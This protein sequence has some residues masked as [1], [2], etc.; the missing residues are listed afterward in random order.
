M[1]SHC[2]RRELQG[3]NTP[4][5]LRNRAG[6]QCSGLTGPPN[7]YL[8][9]LRTSTGASSSAFS[10][11]NSNLLEVPG[12]PDLE[13]RHPNGIRLAPDHKPK[14]DTTGGA[15]K[16]FPA[17]PRNTKARHHLIMFLGASICLCMVC[18]AT[19]RA[20]RGPGPPELLQVEMN[21]RGTE[22]R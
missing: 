7:C 18:A 21:E 22:A 1:P 11:N 14:F 2:F 6:T 20:R 8:C 12:R 15:D 13:I 10:V 17:P 5:S 9:R 3:I 16:A 19:R 4:R